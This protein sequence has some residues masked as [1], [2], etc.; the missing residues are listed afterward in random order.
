MSGYLANVSLCMPTALSF[1]GLFANEIRYFVDS[2]FEDRDLSSIVEDGVTLMKIID[3]I[4]KSAQT[5]SEV[6]I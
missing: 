2:I 6:K 5:G 3:A 4:Y 1:E